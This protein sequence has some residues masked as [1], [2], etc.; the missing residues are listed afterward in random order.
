MWPRQLVA[1][2]THH[3][4]HEAKRFFEIARDEL[5]RFSAANCP[6]GE[7]ELHW[8]ASQAWNRG[9]GF[10][11]DR[12]L[13]VAEGWMSMA[14]TFVGL[15]PALAGFRDQM[16]ESYTLCLSQLSSSNPKE[17]SWRKR[18]GTLLT[19]K[20]PSAIAAVG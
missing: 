4:R 11:L 8:F 15:A 13:E 12:Q 16:T 6:M 1:T 20:A 5:E 17:M 19:G 10:F 3:T 7:D 2:C 9:V 14:F 18:M